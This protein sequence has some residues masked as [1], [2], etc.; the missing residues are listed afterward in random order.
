[1]K[2]LL[3]NPYNVGALGLQNILQVEPLGLEYIGAALAPRQDVRILDLRWEPD[4]E[5]EIRRYRP[6]LVG[7]SCLYTSHTGAT[8]DLARRSKKALPDVPVVAGG[9]PPTLAPEYFASPDID[10]IVL[11]DGEEVLPELCASMEKKR[12]WDGVPGLVLNRGEGQVRTPERRMPQDLSGTPHPKRD[13]PGIFRSKYYLSLQRPTALMEMSRGCPFSCN[14]CSI[15]V[16]GDSK[17]RTRSIDAA[18]EELASIPEM[19]VFLVDDHFFVNVQT[20]EEMGRAIA[21]AKLGKKFQIQT[22]A[23]AIVKNPRLLDVWKE[24]GLHA[25]F[26]GFEGHTDERLREVHK[27]T[28]V[29]NNERAIDL[30]RERGIQLVGNLMIDPAF[31]KEQFEGLRRYVEERNYH[32]ATYCIA[33]PFPGTQMWKA[34]RREVTTFDFELY[35]IHHA[36]METQLPLREFYEEYAR[37]WKLRESLQ[38]KTRFLH[39]AKRTAQIVLR[40]DLNLQLLKNAR[41]FDRLVKDPEF[42]HAGHAAKAPTPWVDTPEPALL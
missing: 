25:V 11:H 32:F 16:F 17:V 36:V 42:I 2:V 24:A 14:F 19:A 21:G 18:I 13:L 28:T 3:V 7:I 9:Q 10:A 5:G 39:T 31:S 29:A 1:M 12:R 37:C 33:T 41:R 34:R 23:D 8:W 22:R 26:I 35:D 20:M 6:D 38:P 4:F 40:G 30:L 27:E 15:W